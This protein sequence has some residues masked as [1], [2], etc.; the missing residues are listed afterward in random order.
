MRWS[1]S[2]SRPAALYGS[3]LVRN[4]AF[5]KQVALGFTLDDWRTTSEVL[6]KHVNSLA[7][8]PPPFPHEP[9]RCWAADPVGRPAF[10]PKTG[11]GLSQLDAFMVSHSTSARINILVSPPETPSPRLT[12]TLVASCLRSAVRTQQTRL[13]CVRLASRVRSISISKA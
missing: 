3:V 11:G 4:I 7:Q 5:E 6:S 2:R 8:L 1:A 13:G 9:S 10:K 12:I